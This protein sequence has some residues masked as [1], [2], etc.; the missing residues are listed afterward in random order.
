VAG[1]RHL[2]ETGLTQ[3]LLYVDESNAAAVALYR[4][5]GFEIYKTGRHVPR[6]ELAGAGDH[7]GQHPLRGCQ[8]ASSIRA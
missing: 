8:V 4:K 5:L 1:L 7:L 2:A 6:A 3:A